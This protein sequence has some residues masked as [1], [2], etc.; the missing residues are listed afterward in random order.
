MAVQFLGLGLTAIKVNHAAQEAAYVAAGSPEAASAR[1][2]CWG[3]AGGLTS[4]DAYS[5]AAICK[6]VMQ[7]LGD[8]NAANVSVAVSPTLLDRGNRAPI[9][10]TVTYRQPIS[11]PLLRLFMGDTF[12]T[13]SDATSWTQ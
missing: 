5:D 6:T 11:S 9:H 12:T 13:S 4:P 2:P 7:N 8:V 3:I 10:V 1:T